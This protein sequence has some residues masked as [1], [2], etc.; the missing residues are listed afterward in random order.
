AD[1]LIANKELAIQSA[2]KAQLAADLLIANKELAIQSAEKAMRAAE[3]VIANKELAFESLEKHKRAAELVIANKELAIQSAEKAERAAELLIANEGLVRQSAEKAERAA[4]LLVANEKLALQSAEKAKRAAE[5]VMT[6][7]ELALQSAEK[8]KRAAELVMTN[9]ELALQSAEKAERAAEAMLV[10]VNRELSRES[11]VRATREAELVI[12]NAKLQTSLLETIELTRQLVE[13]RD[14]FTAGHEMHVGQLAKAIAAQMGF[15]ADRQE[16][17]MVAGYLHDIGK[18]IIPVE[19]LAKPGKISAEEF[20]L[21]KNH[22]QA[23]YDLLKDVGFKWN[24]AQPIYEHH[25]RLDGSGYPRKLKAD[26][27][28]IDGR[29]LAVADVVE[30]IF[31]YRPYRPERGADTGLTV[32]KKGRGTLYDATVVDACIKLFEDGFEFT[33]TKDIWRG[34]APVGHYYDDADDLSGRT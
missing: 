10:I 22:V 7:K 29:I 13:L 17:L 6:N 32:I 1:L 14:P 15:D 20:S 18:I 21:I 16:G 28:S 2:E 8:A 34:G 24:I 12:A 9:K 3:L 30:S 23:G 5:L 19:I 25:E 33:E 4:E 31:H 26:Q 11:T 27:I